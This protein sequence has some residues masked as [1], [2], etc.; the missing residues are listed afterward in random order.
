MKGSERKS[1]LNNHIHLSML[2]CYPSDQCQD[3]PASLVQNNERKHSTNQPIRYSSNPI[4]SHYP[5]SSIDHLD[6]CSPSLKAF[7]PPPPIPMSLPIPNQTTRRRC[8]TTAT[9]QHQ[10]ATRGHQ[11]GTIDRHAILITRHRHTIGACNR[12]HARRRR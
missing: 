12:T 10:I 4:Q 8:H 2:L 9:H 11:N 3:L 6:S 1:V 7:N 5:T